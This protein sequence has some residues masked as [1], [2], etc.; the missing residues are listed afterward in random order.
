LFKSYQFWL[1]HI[2][3]INHFSCPILLI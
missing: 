1:V 2:I 3:T